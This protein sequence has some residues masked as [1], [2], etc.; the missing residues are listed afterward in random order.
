MDSIIMTHWSNNYPW[1]QI[2]TNLPEIAMEDIDAERY[3]QDLKDMH[4]TVA[5]INT[6][7]IIA[8]Y[9][10]DLPFHFQSPRLN[11]DSLEQIIAACHREGIKV[12]ARTDF[13]KV[14]RPVYEQHPE[15]ACIYPGGVIEEYNGNVHCCVNGDYQR[16]YAPKIIEETLTK[17]NV[18]GIFFNMGGYSTR[19]YDHKYLGM[20]QC[21]N[22]QRGF[23]E[24]FGLDLPEKE[25]MGDPVYRKYVVF[26]QQTTFERKQ[27]IVRFIKTIQPDLMIDRS[28]EEDFGFA[29]SESNTEIDRPLPHWQYSGSDNSKRAV[30]SHPNLIASN[31]TVDFI[32]YYYRHVA[33]SPAQQ[34]LRLWQALAA[35]AGLD[36]YLIGRLDNHRDR[37]GFEP[38]KRV[39]SFHEKHFEQTYKGL[40]PKA[41]TLLVD[42]GEYR[43]WFRLL[44]ETHVPFNAIKPGNIMST[45]LS[46]YECV[47]LGNTK[48][49]SDAEAQKVDDFVH[50]GGTLIATGETGF[51]DES[52]EERSS[53]AL[54]SLGIKAT[55]TVDRNMRSALLEVMDKATFPSMADRDLLYFGDTFVF[56]QYEDSAQGMLRLIPPHQYGPPERCYWTE[57]TDLPGLV[58]NTYGKGKAI[59]F[60]WMPGALFYREGYDNTIVFVRDVL[61]Q[62]AQLET[63]S[64]LSP[65]VEA[66]LATGKDFTLLQLVNTSGHFGN[67]FYEPVTMADL[68]IT[69]PLSEEPTQVTRLTDG[70]DV[71]FTYNQGRA[72]LSLSKLEFFEAIKMES[73]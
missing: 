58:V 27:E 49:L 15:W 36:Y 18:D 20:C 65:M 68:E 64:G 28:T 57:E 56:N 38:V 34:E 72:T 6:S 8:S 44:T 69:V 41:S 14:R 26:K 43:G 1:R 23:K 19:N 61:E 73:S 10:T 33:V 60:P 37:S 17:L 32:G 42:G 52:Y 70:A 59:Y 31:T 9:K 30:S 25:D 67:S 40:K 35:C 50:A 29:R 4:A 22:C 62:V 46:R 16:I 3:V 55:E 39:F 2:Q 12:V 7:G 11:G 54:K 48:H 21:E 63:I 71:P 66:T 13:S 24:R 45:D 5:M 51:G 47:V 53:C